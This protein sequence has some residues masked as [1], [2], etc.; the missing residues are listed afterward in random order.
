MDLGRAG[1]V[2]VSFLGDSNELLVQGRPANHSAMRQRNL[3]G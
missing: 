1:F 2:L 3:M